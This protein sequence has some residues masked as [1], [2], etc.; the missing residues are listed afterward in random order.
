M[1]AAAPIIQIDAEGTGPQMAFWN[2]PATFRVLSGGIGS[3][4]TYAGAME[5]MVQPPG[6]VGMVVT[7]TEA[8]A[9]EPIRTLRKIAGPAI[10]EIKKS[11]G[12]RKLVLANG[13]EIFFRSADNPD[14]LRGPNLGWFWMDEGGQLKDAEAW[15]VM[16]GRLRL[17][18]GRGW[19]TTTPAGYNWLYDT[20]VRAKHPG[21]E[22]ITAPTR[23]N[24]LHENADFFAT[25]E[26]SYTGQYARQELEGEFV[27]L[28][29]NR[30]Y[31]PFARERNHAPA[32]W[33]PGEALHVGMDFNVMNMT[34]VVGAIRDDAPVI[35]AELTGVRDTPQMCAMLRDRYPDRS[36]VVYPDASGNSRKSVNAQESDIALLRQA[37]FTIRVN[38]ANP[39]VKDRVAAVN[40]VMAR[41]RIDIDACPRLTE[42][43]EMQSYDKNGEPDKSTGHDHANDALGYF[44]AQRWPIQSRRATV[45]ALR[46]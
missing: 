46:I 8:M 15:Q 35:L 13:T 39:A 24:V 22:V 42:S 14:R 34:A 16:I 1:T 9:D 23:T 26:A 41:L 28:A 20:F 19:V 10:T 21:A 29:G 45:T 18:P 7:P 25:I 12:A 40:A 3:G 44:I 32:V 17:R 37:G 31:E 27:N 38:A 36:I 30:V 4:K 33:Q 43:L 6:S 11:S 2:S 5:C